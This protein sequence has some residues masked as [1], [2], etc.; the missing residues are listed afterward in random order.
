MASHAGS[1]RARR[2]AIALLR[3]YPRPWRARYAHEMQALL[4]DMP[5]GW[6]QVLNIG[7]TAIREWLSPRAFGWPSRSAAGRMQ[8]AR[9]FTFL[10]VGYALDGV[11]R[12]IAWMLKSNGIE[13]SENMQI[14][15]T[16][17]FLAMAIRVCVPGFIRLA[18]RPWIVKARE[19][20]TPWLALRDR[21][22]VV[23][24]IVMMPHLVFMH[25]ETIPSYL[26]P[27]MVAVRPFVHVVQIYVW[28]WTMLQSSERSLRLL[29]VQNE[30]LKRP[31]S[32]W[33]YD[34]R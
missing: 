12:A 14:A 15:G 27:G 24:A 16:A 20:F 4:E 34:R 3:W 8:A 9:T 30:Y 31:W 6:R 10:A 26:S 32:Q 18:K 7:A 13:I 11:A 2:A 29:K 22:I 5:V 1:D 17:V 19:R 23:W 25:A 21:E 33:R 28:A